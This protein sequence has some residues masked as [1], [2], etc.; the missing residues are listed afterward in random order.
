MKAYCT[1]NNGD[2]STC[3]LVNYGHDCQ[4]NRITPDPVPMDKKTFLHEMA[5]ADTM[6][7]VDPPRAEY[8]CGFTRGLRRAHHG[9]RFGTAAEHDL[10]LAAADSDDPTRADRGRGYRDGMQATDPARQRQAARD[11]EIA[12]I[13]WRTRHRPP[14]VCGTGTP[15]TPA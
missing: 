6:R 9:E 4:N 15:T 14:M 11:A 8:W 13:A 2:C 1:Q 7:H 12:A 3:S 10:W 5:R